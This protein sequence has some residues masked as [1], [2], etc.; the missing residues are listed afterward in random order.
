MNLYWYRFTS[1]PKLQEIGQQITVKGNHF[2]GVEKELKDE[3]IEKYDLRLEG[4]GNFDVVCN[5]YF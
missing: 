3:L 5:K 1:M 4:H 2:M